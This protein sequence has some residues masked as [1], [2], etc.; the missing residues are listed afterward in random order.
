MDTNAFKTALNA[1]FTAMNTESNATNNFAANGIFDALKG[2]ISSGVITTVDTGTVG[3]G[4]YSGTGTG[5]MNLDGTNLKND[6]KN[7]FDSMESD[8]YGEDRELQFS[9]DFATALKSALTQENI[10]SFV[11]AGTIT[12]SGVESPYSGTGKGSFVDTGFAALQGGLYACFNAMKTQT[13]SS[14]NPNDYFAAQLS[15]LLLSYLT[16]GVINS[17]LDSPL[18]GAGIGGII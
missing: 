10:I 6:L 18:T 2:F 11:T 14:D 17:V 7:L 5:A 9:I 4:S 13:G 8:D 16:S 15:N 3:G 12:V 1:V